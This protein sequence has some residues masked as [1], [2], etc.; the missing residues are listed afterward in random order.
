MIRTKI[1]LL[2]LVVATTLEAWLLLGLLL[3]AGGLPR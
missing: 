3:L 1:R 2:A